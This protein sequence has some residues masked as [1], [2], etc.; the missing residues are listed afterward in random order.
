MARAGVNSGCRRGS[1]GIA[2]A[3]PGEE[4]SRQSERPG[5][6]AEAEGCIVG[7]QGL[8]RR[9]RRG[10]GVGVVERDED[11][12]RGRIWERESEGHL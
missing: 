12:G 10:Q 9:G 11:R 6:S 1:E 7:E 5:Q 3:I 8:E 2:R 4:R